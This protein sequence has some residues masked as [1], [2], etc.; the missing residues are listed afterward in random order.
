[1]FH[2]DAALRQ[3]FITFASLLL[4]FFFFFFAASQRHAAAASFA[5]GVFRFLLR[6]G[7]RRLLFSHVFAAIRC[8]ALFSFATIM[9]VLCR[10]IAT[11]TLPMPC[12]LD[13]RC[14]LMARCRHTRT[15][16]L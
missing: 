5:D 9:H 13:A 12:L 15:L 14:R 6:H 3:T 4:M 1:M 11:V 7:R 8:Y 10:A 16:L 2:A